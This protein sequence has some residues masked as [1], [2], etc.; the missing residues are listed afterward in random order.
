MFRQLLGGLVAASALLGAA[1][2]AEARTLNVVASFGILAD[3][4]KNV[5]G[6]KANVVSLVPPGGDP[7]VFEP[8][9]TDAKNIAEADLVFVSGLG[10]EGWI[11]RLVEASGYQGKPV[12]VSEGIST[13]STKPP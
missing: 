6:D 2:L 3:V 4:V 13:H 1:G 10:F 11:D 9:P 5:G 12:V 7:H 8:T